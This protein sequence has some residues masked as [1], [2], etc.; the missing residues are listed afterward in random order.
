MQLMT[1]PDAAAKDGVPARPAHLDAE[2]ALIGAILLGASLA[3]LRSVL[4]VEDFAQPWL[5]AAY[6]A[7]LQLDSGGKPV[8]NITLAAALEQLKA[9][10]GEGTML[11]RVNGRAGLQVLIQECPT[12]RNALHYAGLIAT[13]AAER[14]GG[15]PATR[16]TGPTLIDARQLLATELREP[17][18]AV[19]GIIPEGLT[20]LAGK[21]KTGKSWLGLGTGIAVA[22]GGRALGRIQVDRGDVLY[23]ALEDT[24]RRLQERLKAI[25]RDAPCP[26]GLTLA[27]SWPRSGQGGNE[28]LLRWLD[29]HKQ[30]RLVIIDTLARIRPS[31]G[32]NGNLYEE[33]Y[34]AVSALKR[35]ADHAGA[36]F[37]II[38]HLRKMGS[39]DAFDTVSGTA[40]LTGA[41]DATIILKRERAHRDATLA[42]TG[43]DIEEREIG[44]RWDPTL[45]SWTL[46]GEA[47]LS[48]E[49]TAILMALQSAGSSLTPTQL[50]A[51]LEKPLAPVKLLMWR[52]A[53]EGQLI[54]DKKGRYTPPGNS[55]NPS[56]QGNLGYPDTEK[57]KEGFPGFQGFPH[58][59]TREPEPDGEY[60]DALMV[61]ADEHAHEEAGE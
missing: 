17:N 38:T 8:D 14:S 57:P 10:A 54:A 18:F 32:R 25:L 48:D 1:K 12:S 13:A 43:R 42:M 3:T 9:P 19:P 23:L 41:A 34:A 26:A 28:E 45:T 61:D 6:A 44:I 5:G 15:R 35:L 51:V 21:P 46:R 56:N 30:T 16:R 55:I 27:T 11:D 58:A 24:Q 49:R 20:I 33:D 4:Q 31:H 40:G 7:A 36:A 39:D 60:L 47:D 52:M 59:R 29:A 2:R 22:S 53:G 37:L 50:A